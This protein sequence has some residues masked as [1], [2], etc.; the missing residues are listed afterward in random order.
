MHYI[1][2]YLKDPPIINQY[3]WKSKIEFNHF[4]GLNTLNCSVYGLICVKK[5]SEHMEVCLGCGI[6]LLQ[7]LYRYKISK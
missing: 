1:S 7:N 3:W 6:S 5:S 4:Q 2:T